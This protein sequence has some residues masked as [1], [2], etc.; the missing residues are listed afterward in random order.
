MDQ[1]VELLAGAAVSLLVTRMDD[2]LA[3]FA[4]S[5]QPAQENR[6]ET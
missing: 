4:R 2:L 1:L 5:A 3:L 6:W